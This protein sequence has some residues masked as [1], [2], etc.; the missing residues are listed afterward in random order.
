VVRLTK[1]VWR[2]EGQACTEVD[3][4]MEQGS[5]AASYGKVQ[6]APWLRWRWEGKL[7]FSV[8]FSI[9]KATDRSL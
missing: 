4:N 1:P 7:P 5:V 3:W 8:A 9:T 2:P 6:K